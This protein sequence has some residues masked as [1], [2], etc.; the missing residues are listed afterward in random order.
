MTEPVIYTHRPIRSWLLALLTSD[1]V[2]SFIWL[3]YFWFI[4]G[5]LHLAFY[6]YPVPLIADPMG[7]HV[8]DAWAWMPLFACPIAL[9]GVILRYGG[10]PTDEINGPPLR[11][12]FLGLY[13]QIGGHGCMTVVLAIF[14]GTAIYGADP[15]QPTPSV[16]WLCAYLMGVMFLTAQCYYK[17][18]LARKFRNAK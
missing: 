13:M 1:S 5:S 3:Y 14:I 6:A 15:G 10:S 17:V 16:Y 12:D 11:R 7:L 2:R 8:Y 9:G 4:V 18:R